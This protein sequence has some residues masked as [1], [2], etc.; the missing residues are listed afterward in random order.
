MS[1]SHYEVIVVTGMKIAK[2][3]DKR[4]GL[5]WKDQNKNI[6]VEIKNTKCAKTKYKQI[7][8]AMKY[9]KLNIKGT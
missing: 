8:I 6:K 4:L 3:N 7:F 5:K 1:I 2:T 9:A